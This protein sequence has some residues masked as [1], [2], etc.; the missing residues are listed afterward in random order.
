MLI[1]LENL[2]ARVRSASTEEGAWLREYLSFPDPKARFRY[3][4]NDGKVHMYNAFADTF[5]AGF[6]PQVKKAAA[7]E[8][9]EVQVLDGRAQP[10][11][12][13][14][15]EA[16][17]AWLRPNQVGA[18]KRVLERRRGILWLPTGFGKTEVVV[19]LTRAAPVR[20]LFMV[21]RKG[22]VADAAARYDK[23]NAEHLTGLPPAGVIGE[24]GWQE[25]ARFT[26]ATL[27]TLA[28][29]IKRG[30]ERT[31]QLL[32]SCE[33]ILVDECHT[34]P[35]DSYMSVI[36]ETPNAFY[37]VG[38][39]GT[40]LARGDRR[41]IVA[42]G[43]L[44]PVIY[45]VEADEL[46]GQGVLAKPKIRMATVTQKTSTAATYATVY[47]EKVVKSAT[48]NAKLV[49]LAQRAAKP[50][51]LFVQE[52]AHGRALVKALGMN[53][54]K[55]EFAYGNHSTEYRRSLIKRMV[56]G[57][58]D[59]LVCS[60]VFQEGVD[61]PELHSIINGAGGKSII[62]ALQRVGRGMRLDPKDP[63]K[64]T[65]EV[66]DIMDRGVTW[67]ERH[68]AERKHAFLSQKYET[69]I[70]PETPSSVFMKE[71]IA[72]G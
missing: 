48:R 2:V 6:L 8:G 42:V 53:G 10:A 61:I 22:L 20:W 36:N 70:E 67:L 40:P 9:I 34:A 18:V 54:V 51:L 7:A 15:A 43:S 45:K 59:I 16:D 13:E 72:T 27:Q 55:A 58:F 68:S 30:D 39:S 49:E 44:G 4:K 17:L 31:L 50:G 29:G 60:V 32:H 24:G 37:R 35:A 25:D 41:S 33:G 1:R 47:R 38:L 63:S 28:A 57:H 5:P 14:D 11:G 71:T 64:T 23:R 46:I 66:Y 52:I 69:I 21:H 12:G 3:G 56:L 62:A 65:F 19:G 26:C